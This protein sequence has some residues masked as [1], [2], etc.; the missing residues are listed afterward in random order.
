LAH[1]ESQNKNVE[2]TV[3]SSTVI[4]VEMGEHKLCLALSVAT[5]G[6]AIIRTKTPGKD[7]YISM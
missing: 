4:S 6:T 3:N 7:G 5:T 2:V 1:K